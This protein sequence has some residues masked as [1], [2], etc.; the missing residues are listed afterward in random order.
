MT[1]Y[2]ADFP[3]PVAFPPQSLQQILGEIVSK[4]GLRQ[5]RI[6]ETE[7]YAHVTYFFN[8]GREEP[9]AREERV[10]VH[11]PRDV[12]TYDLKPQMSA[13]EITDRLLL[14]VAQA[15]EEGAPYD[16]IVLN[17]A[18]GDM[19]GHTGVLPAAIRACETVDSCVGR[20]W[21]FLRGR[22]WTMLVTADHGNCEVMIDRDGGPHTA[23]TTNPLL[24]LKFC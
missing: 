2:E 24:Y 4:R 21:D 7:K 15:E 9:Y 16:L 22:G 17:F 3:F 11:S 23:Y 5:L 10:L 6:A 20:I 19:V 13:E 14:K 18:N 12:A 8:G 1:E